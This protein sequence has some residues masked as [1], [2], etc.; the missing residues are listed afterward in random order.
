M[1]L[2]LPLVLASIAFFD[3]L[4]ALMYIAMCF[5]FEHSVW[6]KYVINM[7]V[8]IGRCYMLGQPTT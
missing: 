6:I 4:H 8:S 5:L 7:F 1:L 3:A 2:M